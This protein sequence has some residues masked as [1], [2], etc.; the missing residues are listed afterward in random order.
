MALNFI[1]NGKSK[2]KGVQK[3]KNKNGISESVLREV[4]TEKIRVAAWMKQLK[5]KETFSR[6]WMSY[7]LLELALQCMGKLPITHTFKGKQ[8]LIDAFYP[9]EAE[10]LLRLGAEV[11][12]LIGNGRSR[13]DLLP[14]QRAIGE[15]KTE[16]TEL[17]TDAERT[18]EV[19]EILLESDV[20]AEQMENAE[21]V[22]T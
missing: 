22:E 7:V 21:I 19:F 13:G 1:R 4:R 11:N 9:K 6:E 10:K 15:D 20:F 8:I 14:W 3:C 2:Q 12:N 16:S 18:Q 5:E 17:L